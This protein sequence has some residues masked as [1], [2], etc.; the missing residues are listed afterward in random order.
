MKTK[1]VRLLPISVLLFSMLGCTNGEENLAGNKG[2][3]V[4]AVDVMIAKKT[5]V[6]NVIN[7]NG[8]VLA[9][10]ESELRNEIPGRIVALPFEEG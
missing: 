10:E 2:G 3:G 6:D 8:S 7:L 1:T 5:S 4:M 9:N